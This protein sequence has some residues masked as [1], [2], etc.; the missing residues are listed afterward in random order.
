MTLIINLFGAPCAGKSVLR[1][2]L[3][4]AMK[5]AGHN[6]EEVTEYAK[7]VVWEERVTLFSDQLYILA[8]QNR[9]LFR[10]SGKVDFIITDSPLLMS[11]AYANRYVVYNPT[12]EKLTV[13]VFSSYNNLNI[14]LN[15]THGY[16]T[17]GRNQDEAASL[18]LSDQIKQ[19]LREHSFGFTEYNS[20]ECTY[21]QLAPEIKK[22]EELLK[23]KKR[24]V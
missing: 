24:G 13:D 7:D 10:L 2:E 1:A 17:L 19:L 11:I 20:N 18:T 6:V 12:L 14:F 21:Q 22:Y 23:L 16:Q 9:K 15:R 8:K 4:A 5:K 3:F